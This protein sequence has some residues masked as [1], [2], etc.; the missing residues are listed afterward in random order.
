MPP[1]LISQN[2]AE[3]WSILLTLRCRFQTLPAGVPGP[4]TTDLRF[5]TATT[6]NQRTFQSIIKG[7]VPQIRGEYSLP[8]DASPT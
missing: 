4:M 5:L 7:L 6:E 8:C 2:L 1:N 3:G